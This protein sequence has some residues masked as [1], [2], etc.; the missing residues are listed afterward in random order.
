M[1]L[2]YKIQLSMMRFYY[3]VL[4]KLRNS[5]VLLLKPSKLSQKN[6]KKKTKWKTQNN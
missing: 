2:N 1:G 3:E 5:F 6:L 4:I